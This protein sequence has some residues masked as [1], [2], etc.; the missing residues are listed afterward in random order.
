[1]L[2][3]K[4]NANL[5]REFDTSNESKRRIIEQLVEAF[6]QGKIQIIEETRL[7]KQLQ[8]YAAEKTPGG[9][10][11]YNGQNGIN[12]DAVIALALV[13]DLVSK[14]TKKPRFGFA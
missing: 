13:Y 14:P 1:M 2:K 11:T 7:I 6:L 8:N 9:K 3:R 12:D 10:I 5:I 4:I